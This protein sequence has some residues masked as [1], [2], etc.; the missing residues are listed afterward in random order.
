METGLYISY[1]CT[2]TNSRKMQELAR[3]VPLSSV[4]LGTGCPHLLPPAGTK[5]PQNEPASVAH[6]A[7]YLAK[8]LDLP[9][10]QVC[11]V[12]TENAK[13]LFEI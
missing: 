13:K 9:F 6:T 12:T 3:S 2:L 11:Q 7:E 4:L 8:L 1:S 10:E 5:P